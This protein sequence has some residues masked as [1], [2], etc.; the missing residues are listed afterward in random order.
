MNLIMLSTILVKYFM[1][2]IFARFHYS[3][4]TGGLKFNEIDGT[5]ALLLSF[6]FITRECHMLKRVR[7][8]RAAPDKN[9]GTSPA[10]GKSKSSSAFPEAPASRELGRALHDR[11]RAGEPQIMHARA[12]C[13]RSRAAVLSGKT[14][15][16]LACLRGAVSGGAEKEKGSRTS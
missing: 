15:H 10:Q 6:L 5:A 1:P 7:P 4:V 8:V 16:T 9:I 2:P 11:N 3:S 12:K 14:E 13:K